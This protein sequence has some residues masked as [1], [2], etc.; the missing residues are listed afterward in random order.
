MKIFY[1]VILMCLF[2]NFQELK[3]QEAQKWRDSLQILNEKIR[4]NPSSTDLRL[5]KAAV[6]IELAQWE[7][8]ADEYSRVLQLEP[9]N[10]AALYF[11]A[12]VNTTLRHYDLAKYDYEQFLSV[13]PKHFEAMVG[14]ATV[15][16]KMGRKVDALDEMNKIVQL[17]PDS[18]LAYA[19]RAGYEVELEQYEPALFDWDEAIRREPKNADFIVSKI[20]LLVTMKRYEEA[21]EVRKEAIKRGVPSAALRIQIP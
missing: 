19:L 4:L 13:M 20:D 14:L 7:Y 2:L 6:N 10:L 16:R 3:A 1:S 5:K 17:F 9:K 12:Y 18:T 11:R 15:K 8:A 21:R